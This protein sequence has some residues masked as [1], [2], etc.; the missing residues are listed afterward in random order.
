MA[1]SSTN[2]GA[3]VAGYGYSARSSAV[4]YFFPSNIFYNF[5]L[6]K[7]ELTDEQ[8]ALYPEIAELREKIERLQVKYLLRLY[9]LFSIMYFPG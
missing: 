9:I 6:S 5:F 7:I 2:Y 4:K 3:P 8:K 1:Y